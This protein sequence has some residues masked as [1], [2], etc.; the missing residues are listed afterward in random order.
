MPKKLLFILAPSLFLLLNGAYFWVVGTHEGGISLSDGI[1]TN[2][3]WLVIATCFVIG[4]LVS[5]RYQLLWPV[6]FVFATMTW[7]QF[8][9]FFWWDHQTTYALAAQ[10]HIPMIWS[11]PFVV[12]AGLLFALLGVAARWTVSKSH[13]LQRSHHLGGN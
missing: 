8:L 4:W 11:L 5:Y 3:F 9:Q 10:D 1:F 6:F 7:L 13:I 2:A 12:V